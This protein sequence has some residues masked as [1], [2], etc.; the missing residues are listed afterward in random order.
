MNVIILSWPRARFRPVFVVLNRRV[1]G[2]GAPHKHPWLKRESNPRC[3]V[4]ERLRT[5]R[6]LETLSTKNCNAATWTVSTLK[7]PN[8]PLLLS[9]LKYIL[10]AGLDSPRGVGTLEEK[11]L[12]QLCVQQYDGSQEKNKVMRTIFFSF[13]LLGWEGRHYSLFKP[14]PSSLLLFI[15]MSNMLQHRTWDIQQFSFSSEGNNKQ[16]LSA[17]V[18]ISAMF[19]ERR[20][21]K[22]RF[23]LHIT[24]C[25]GSAH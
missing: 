18:V 13:F 6:W 4:F 25:E 11:L 12:E 23:L 3:L 19:L 16:N 22:I 5:V 15:V 17:R 24:C 1:V 7:L 9:K 14:T 10:C 8:G 21:I 20:D 2:G